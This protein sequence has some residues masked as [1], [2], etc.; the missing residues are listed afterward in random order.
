MKA[1][2]RG[3]SFIVT[4]CNFIHMN[5]LSLQTIGVN[6]TSK[7]E[8]IDQLD[9]IDRMLSNSGIDNDYPTEAIY[10]GLSDG[11]ILVTESIAY[12]K[13]LRDL[14]PGSGAWDTGWRM[15]CDR[16][17]LFATDAAAVVES[18]KQQSS[19]TEVELKQLLRRAQRYVDGNAW[20]LHDEIDRALNLRE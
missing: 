12:I 8:A 14:Y 7:Q 19:P 16:F 18:P 4:A 17:E 1:S 10:A 3:L 6:M 11:T 15:A 13:A 5:L 20:E 9:A 2:V